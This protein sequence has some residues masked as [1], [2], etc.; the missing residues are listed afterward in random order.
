GT[1]SVQELEEAVA[2]AVDAGTVIP[3]FCTAGKKEIGVEQLL[4][5]LAKYSST[6]W[7]AKVRL[8]DHLHGHN[9]HE[10]DYDGADENGQ[11]LGG[12]FQTVNHKVVGHIGVI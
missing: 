10:H 9:G 8:A 3:I 1:L 4:H 12:V 2:K 6:P 5:A 11:L 7:H